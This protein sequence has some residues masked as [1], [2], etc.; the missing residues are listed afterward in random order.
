MVIISVFKGSSEVT[1]FY[2]VIRAGFLPYIREA[3]CF[4]LLPQRKYHSK[5]SINTV[6]TGVMILLKTAAAI[7]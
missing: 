2:P 1:S 7:Y 5:P 6:M 3:L 4:G